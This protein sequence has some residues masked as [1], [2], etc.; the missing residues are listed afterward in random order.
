MNSFIYLS[1]RTFR[2]LLNGSNQS[3]DQ[4]VASVERKKVFDEE[5]LL[6]SSY[7]TGKSKA[8]GNVQRVSA[9]K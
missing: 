8:S 5:Y 3:S 9:E 1:L 7:Q 6:F 2:S 4:L